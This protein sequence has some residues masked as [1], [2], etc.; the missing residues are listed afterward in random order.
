[1]AAASEQ[2]DRLTAL[3]LV[4]FHAGKFTEALDHFDR[5]VQADSGDAYARYYRAVTRGRRGEFAGAVDDLRIVVAARP[6]L[7]QAT[8]EMGVALVQTGRYEE[9]LAWLKRAQWDADSEAQASLFLGLAQLRLGHR[10]NARA[11]FR[12]A[13]ARDP[14]LAHTLR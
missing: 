1:M 2:S 14:A 11:H 4:E 12:R 3:G 9:A 5:A 10:E 7:K 6:D 13:A 8:R